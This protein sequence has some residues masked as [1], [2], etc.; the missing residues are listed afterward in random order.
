[1]VVC[2]FLCTNAPLWEET[3]VQRKKMKIRKQNETEVKG[4]KNNE[5]RNMW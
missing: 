2:A 3:K 4:E 1:M 5:K